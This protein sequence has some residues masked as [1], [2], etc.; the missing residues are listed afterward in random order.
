MSRVIPLLLLLLLLEPAPL[1]LKVNIPRPPPPLPPNWGAPVRAY[2]TKEVMP[3]PPGDECNRGNCQLTLL[4][5]RSHQ[6]C[7]FRD[8]SSASWRDPSLLCVPGTGGLAVGD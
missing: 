6:T 7:D 3:A 5:C 2:P 8:G 1:R 4:L